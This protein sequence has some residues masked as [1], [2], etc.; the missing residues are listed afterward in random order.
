MKPAKNQNPLTS[1]PFFSLILRITF[2][3]IRCTDFLVRL[4]QFQFM[5]S[6]L[7]EIK[8]I[9]KWVHMDGRTT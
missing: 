6:S 1:I 8:L 4:V 7:N 9:A 2:R 5:T 3:H